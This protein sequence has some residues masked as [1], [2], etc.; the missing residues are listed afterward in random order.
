MQIRLIFIFLFCFNVASSQSKTDTL[1]KRYW[2]NGRAAM[3]YINEKGISAEF[4][5]I[6]TMESGYLYE[7]E[8]IGVWES[9]NEKG[10]IVAHNFFEPDGITYEVQYYKGKIY[11]VVRSKTTSYIKPNGEQ[12]WSIQYLDVLTFDKRG[13]IK[14]RLINKPDGKD[15]LI[16]Y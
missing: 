12:T 11:S 1:E 9:K 4:E 10:K 5:G 3:N 14:S 15:S 7:T 13:R 8:R 2:Y 16:R 6:N